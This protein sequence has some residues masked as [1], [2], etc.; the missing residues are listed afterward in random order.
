MGGVGLYGLG[1]AMQYRIGG[2]I[3]SRCILSM[4]DASSSVFGLSWFVYVFLGAGSGRLVG[5]PWPNTVCV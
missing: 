1:V 4:R 5:D 2:A 3:F